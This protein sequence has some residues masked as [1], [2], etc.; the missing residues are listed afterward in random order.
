MENAVFLG[1]TTEEI[2]VFEK[3]DNVRQTSYLYG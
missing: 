1:S 2:L 3:E